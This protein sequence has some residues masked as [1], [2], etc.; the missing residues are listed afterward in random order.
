MGRFICGGNLL[1]GIMKPLGNSNLPSRYMF[2]VPLENCNI[3]LAP[4]NGLKHFP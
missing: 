4:L 2:W 1:T 3:I